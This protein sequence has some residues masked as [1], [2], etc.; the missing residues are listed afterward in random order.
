MPLLATYRH[1]GG[2]HPETAA[3]TNILA[4]KQ[5][6]A[7]HT[8]R[9]FSEAMLLGISGGLGMGYILWEFQEHRMQHNIKVL[10]L[11]FQNTWQYPVKYYEAV[12]RR[13]GLSFSIPETGSEKA[14]AQALHAALAQSTPVVA[15]VDGASMPYF[16]LP[17]TLEGHFGHVV[18]VCGTEGDAVLV[19]DL[20]T[21]P[22]R[23]PADVFARA[24]A[25]IGSYKHRLLVVEGAAAGLDL[26]G[27]ISEGIALCVEQLGSDSESFSLPALRKWARL[28]TDRKNKKGWP[29]LFADRRGL[30]STFVSLFEAIELQGAPGGLRG[31]YADFLLEAAAVIDNP[32]L[33]EPA[34]HYAALA[35]QWHALAEEALPDAVPQFKRA[36]QLLRARHA[37]LRRGGEA[38]RTTQPLTEELRSIRSACNLDF[39][40]DDQEIADL[41]AALQT[42]LQAIY[43]AE[44][45]AVQALNAALPQA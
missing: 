41:F 2:V 7:P 28:M 26:E 15:W 44:V 14:A 1:F 33:G 16:Q 34:R 37:V 12:C 43:Q 42:R 19:D 4:A 29:V 22:F 35:G 5:I 27:A 18:A 30:Y 32:H 40:L 38:W 39:P 23:V 36:K 17:E 13:L 10:V 3:L 45:A 9:P 6:V 20:A 24:R 8:G 11:A 25:R 21:A 31:L